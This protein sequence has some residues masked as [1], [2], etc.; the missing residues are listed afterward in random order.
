[1][2]SHYIQMI[3]CKITRYVQ[4]KLVSCLSCSLFCSH[5]EPLHAAGNHLLVSQQIHLVIS[6]SIYWL[7]SEMIKRQTAVKDVQGDITSSSA[8]PK[9]SV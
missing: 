7:I 2:R 5:R 9:N 6:F 4:L 8:F 1:M 3:E